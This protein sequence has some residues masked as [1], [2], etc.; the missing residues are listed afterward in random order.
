MTSVGRRETNE[1]RNIGMAQNEH[2]RSQPLAIFS[3]AQGRASSRERTNCSPSPWPGS[4][5]PAA[6]SE[7]STGDSG[8]SMRRSE[9]TWDAGRAPPR[10]AV[11]WLDMSR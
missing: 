11:R 7:R 8:S 2:R 6:A 1:P 4:A 5:T 3:G 9:G 10:M